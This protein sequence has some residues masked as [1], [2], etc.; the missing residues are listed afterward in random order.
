[1]ALEAGTTVM[2]TMNVQDNEDVY[3][4]GCGL[5]ISVKAEEICKGDVFRLADRQEKLVALTNAHICSNGEVAI[6]SENL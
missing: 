1:M 4:L 3:S 5:E 2:K 6:P